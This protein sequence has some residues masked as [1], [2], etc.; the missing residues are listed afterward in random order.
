[1][2]D[3]IPIGA[4]GATG[5]L[6]TFTI[7]RKAPAAFAADGVYAVAVVDLAGGKRVV[8]RVEPFEPAPRLGARVRLAR[9]LKDIPVFTPD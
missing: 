4:A 5:T 3:K 1:M 7:I 2:P 8:G 6:V 9:W